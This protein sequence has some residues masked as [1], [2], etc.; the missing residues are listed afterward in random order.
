MSNSIHVLNGEKIALQFEQVNLIGE[1]VVFNETLS[2]GPIDKDVGSDAFFKL[3][4]AYFEKE[5]QIDKLTYFDTSIKPLVK[6]ENADAYNKVVLW[7]DYNLVSQ[8]NMLA[9]CTYLLKNYRKDN[10][11]YLVCV[12]EKEKSQLIFSDNIS[13]KYEELYQ[14]KIKLTRNNLVY[15]KECW[16]LFVNNDK[17]ELENFNFN[18][19]DKFKYLQKAI[20]HY[21][22]GFSNKKNESN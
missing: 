15:A 12:G 18:K 14:H 3:R 7:F 2:E 20:Q 13:K 10:Q 4:Y 1:Q 19:S 21:L 6:L 11:Y 5:Y 17:E 22:N 9:V 8:I 16:D